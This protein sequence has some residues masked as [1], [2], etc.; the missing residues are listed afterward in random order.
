V[1]AGLAAELMDEL[2]KTAAGIAEALR[3]LGTRSL[4]NKIGPQGFIL[5]VTGVLG[6]EKE[7]SQ[8]H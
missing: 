1:L 3:D 4:L 5:T 8:I 6:S 2:M 7:L